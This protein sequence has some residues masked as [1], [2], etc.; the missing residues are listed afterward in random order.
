LHHK[1]NLDKKFVILE[2]AHI[3]ILLSSSPFLENQYAPS[4][5]GGYYLA[6]H[7]LP[8]YFFACPQIG[9]RKDLYLLFKSGIIRALSWSMAR[10]RYFGNETNDNGKR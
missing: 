4:S 9:R 8:R 10:L 1:F 2:N 6:R 5:F 7:P 3:L